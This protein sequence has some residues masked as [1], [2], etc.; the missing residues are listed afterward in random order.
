M[1]AFFSGDPLPVAPR[2]A[3]GEGES[4]K[5]NFIEIERFN[6]KLLEYLRRLGLHLSNPDVVTTPSGPAVESLVVVRI[7]SDQTLSGDPADVIWNQ[8]LR[9]DAPFVYDTSTG[10]VTIQED[11]F[12]LFLVDLHMQDDARFTLE[13]YDG[14]TTYPYGRV[15]SDSGLATFY[16]SSCSVPMHLHATQTMQVRIS[17]AS[18]SRIQQQTMR[19][20]VLKLGSFETSTPG[21]TDPC[22]LDIWQLCP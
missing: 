10:I 16:Q 18:G 1:S 14:T 6:E 11:G 3:D 20:T 9:A 22:D 19:M 12:Y 17:D 4:L 5:Q 21:G 7:T 13:F 8:Q 15:V 2:L